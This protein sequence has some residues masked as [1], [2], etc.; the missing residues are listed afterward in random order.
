MK[1]A[2]VFLIAV[3]LYALPTSG[4][5]QPAAAFTV[6][7]GVALRSFM[8]LTDGHLSTMADSLETL[9][10]T[11]SARSLDW[12][13]IKGAL[14][15][16]GQVNV[17]AVL[18]FALP[19]GSYY[20]LLHGREKANI[21]DRAYFQRAMSGRTAIGELVQSRSSGRAVA[22]VAVPI[23]N[24]KGSVIG[25]LG[26]AIY[27][28]SLTALIK[29][30]MDLGPDDIFYTLDSHARVGISW[31]GAHLLEGRKVSPAMMKVADDILSHPRGAATYT[32]KGR[33]RTILYEKSGVTGWWYAFGKLR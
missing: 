28:D 25:I 9:A 1:V 24:A 11:D 31:E 17:P 18:S 26:G 2:R 33:A 20:T 12:T 13:R 29:Q 23:L 30:E 3:A 16:V 4:G 5:A 6:N 22:V 21:A 8:S 19:D 10:S 15:R 27:L 32:Y 14:E 7:G